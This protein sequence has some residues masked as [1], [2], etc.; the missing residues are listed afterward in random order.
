[1]DDNFQGGW[2]KV[3]DISLGMMM[4]GLL[5]TAIMKVWAISWNWC[6]VVGF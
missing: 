3:S 2:G 1:M 5:V 4:M 6:E